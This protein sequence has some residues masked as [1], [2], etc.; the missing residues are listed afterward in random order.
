MAE[1]EYLLVLSRDLRFLKSETFDALLKEVSDIARML[2]ALR[3]RVETVSRQGCTP[4]SRPE[5]GSAAQE[6]EP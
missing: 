2:N 4:C 3:L 6:G 5:S 1:T